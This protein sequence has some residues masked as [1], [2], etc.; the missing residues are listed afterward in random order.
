MLESIMFMREHW[1]IVYRNN[2]FCFNELL[3]IDKL[4]NMHHENIQKLGIELY[5]RKKNLSNQIM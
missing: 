2:S 5:K 3:K 4:Y 1:G